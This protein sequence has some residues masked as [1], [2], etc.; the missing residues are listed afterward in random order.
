[1]ERTAENIR[2][3]RLRRIAAPYRNRC[4]RVIKFAGTM[5]TARRRSRKVPARLKCS[6]RPASLDHFNFTLAWRM[7]DAYVFER[8]QTPSD[9]LSDSRPFHLLPTG[10]NI[11]AEKPGGY[12]FSPKFQSLLDSFLITPPTICLRIVENEQKTRRRVEF[13]W[14]FKY[15]RHETIRTSNSSPLVANISVNRENY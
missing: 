6:R 9:L 3:I 15:S 14:F 4:N 11:L 12:D 13:F 5:G 2:N 8:S 10:I 1:M 7:P